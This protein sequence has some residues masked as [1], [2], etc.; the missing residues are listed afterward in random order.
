[1]SFRF[2]LRLGVEHF[3]Q[4]PVHKFSRLVDNVI[5]KH[6]VPRSLT[7]LLSGS[8]DSL[9]RLRARPDLAPFFSAVSPIGVAPSGPRIIPMT[10]AISIAHLAAS[11]PRLNFVGSARSM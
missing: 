3:V 6:D 1:M 5:L 4:N 9:A 8:H 2:Q 10:A 11:T 7:R